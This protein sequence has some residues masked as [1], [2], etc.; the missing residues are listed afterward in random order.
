MPH[1][2]RLGAMKVCVGMCRKGERSAVRKKATHW[3]ADIFPD[4]AT[5]AV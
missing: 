2:V 3:L 1:I 4:H 5:L